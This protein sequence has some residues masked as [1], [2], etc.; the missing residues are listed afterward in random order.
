M[1]V[2]VD[3]L[4]VDGETFVPGNGVARFWRERVGDGVDA[5]F[6][7]GGHEKGGAVSCASH[8]ESAAEDVEED[9][10]FV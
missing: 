10:L 5:D 1:V 7:F 6:E 9:L 3:E 8:D 2:I 4:A